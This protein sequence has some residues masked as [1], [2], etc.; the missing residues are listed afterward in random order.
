MQSEYKI[1]YIIFPL[2]LELNN[3][4]DKYIEMELKMFENKL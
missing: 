4:H 2:L 3:K 1:K